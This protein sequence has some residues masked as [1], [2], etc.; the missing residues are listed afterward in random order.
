MNRRETTLV[1][2]V[3]RSRPLFFQPGLKP[4]SAELKSVFGL[5]STYVASQVLNEIVECRHYS[6]YCMITVQDSD[7]WE[8]LEMRYGGCVS[9]FY[10]REPLSKLLARHRRKQKTRERLTTCQITFLVRLRV[11]HIGNI[12][13]QSP[14]ISCPSRIS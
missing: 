4:S 7:Q 2:G 12:N 8:L 14:F 1:Q 6:L 11:Q 10:S 3:S 9:W 13:S 5:H